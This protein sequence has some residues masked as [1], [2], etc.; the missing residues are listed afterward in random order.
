M[1][2]ITRANWK[3]MKENLDI[4]DFELT[5]DEMRQISTLNENKTLSPWTENWK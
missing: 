1:E 3:A 4:F 5:G 2:V